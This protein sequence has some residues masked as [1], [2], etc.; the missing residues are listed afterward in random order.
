MSEQ[1]LMWQKIRRRRRVRTKPADIAANLDR[2]AN[3]YATNKPGLKSMTISADNAWSL[4][5]A[6]KSKENEVRLSG[7]HIADSGEISWRGF[8]LVEQQA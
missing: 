7:F 6:W 3:F 2:L 8:D 4:R 1:A 5:E